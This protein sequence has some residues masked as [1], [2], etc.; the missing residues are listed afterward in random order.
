MDV[1]TALGTFL[2][3]RRARFDDVRVRWPNL[4]VIGFNSLFSE[5]PQ[6]A[7]VIPGAP[8]RHAALPV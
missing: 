4:R 1:Q 6:G 7:T 2:P 3:R 8:A 5:Q